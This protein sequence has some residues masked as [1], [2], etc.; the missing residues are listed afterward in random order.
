MEPR[1]QYAKSADGT[2]I[3]CWTMGAGKPMVYRP[4]MH[5]GESAFWAVPEIARWNEA[6]ASRRLLIRYDPRGTG[7]SQRGLEDY[8]LEAQVAD[9]EAVADR[10]ARGA[11]DLFGMS[12][13]GWRAA[14]AI[15]TGAG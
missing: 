9:L 11:F 3:A 14:N 8:S 6:L 12:R 10:L 2:R 4:P 15:A 1:I 7:H 13:S 5:W